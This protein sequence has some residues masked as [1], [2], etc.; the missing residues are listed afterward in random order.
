[1]DFAIG[2]V[3]VGFE[4]GTSSVGIMVSSDRG[5]M[6]SFSVPQVSRHGI[7]ALKIAVGHLA[8]SVGAQDKPFKFP[9]PST[10]PL[11]Y[12]SAVAYPSIHFAS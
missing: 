7:T 1:M 12:N 11:K 3:V 2:K 4:V 9:I 8:A 10:S 5:G 6:L